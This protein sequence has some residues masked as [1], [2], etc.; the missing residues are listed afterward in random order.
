M[1][2]SRVLFLGVSTSA[3][4]VHR[5]MPGWA[6]AL[7][8]DVTLEGVDLPIGA[9]AAAYVT[10]IDRIL[11]DLRILGMVVTTH[12]AALWSACEASFAQVTALAAMLREVGGVSR[13]SG[14][15]T[16]D[17][18]DVRSVGRAAL[19][20][21]TDERWATGPRHAL[22]LGAGGAGLSL[23]YN[24]S[25]RLPEIAAER[26]VLTELDP[27]RVTTVRTIV[28]G[29]DRADAITVDLAAPGINDR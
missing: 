3:S 20:L 7:D 9:P 23:A 22:I 26:V 13:V 18:P 17:A 1:A 29:W 25:D 10:V 2:A 12:K 6:A 28:A 5:A 24:L 4:S 19:R 15:L 8:V 27:A 14:T 21:L 11:R 16:A